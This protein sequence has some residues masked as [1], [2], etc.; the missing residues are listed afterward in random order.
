MISL[1]ESRTASHWR[2]IGSG[3]HHGICLPLFSLR[4]EKSS[5]IGEFN[6]L[7]PLIDWCKSVGF[8]CL[9]LL[10]LNDTGDDP[11]P[12]NALTSCGLDPVYL[13]L[14]D[15]PHAGALPHISPSSVK[16][17]KLE[18]LY[19]YFKRTFIPTPDYQTFCQEAPW[20]EEYAL[21]KACKDTYR[22]ADWRTWPLKQQSL[23]TCQVEDPHHL[24]FYRFLQFL[25]FR[26]LKEVKRYAEKQNVLLKGDIPILISPDSVD[27]WAHRSLFNLQLV[28]GAPPD[29]YSPRGQKWGFPLFQMDEMRRTQFAWWK[30]RLSVAEQF[31][32][33]YRIDHVV[34][35]FRIW[36]IKHDE[37]AIKGQFF[38]PDESLWEP[39]GREMLEILIEASS[40]LPL[41]EDLGTIP[42]IVYSTL[43]E[44]GI[45]GT[46]VM[47][48]QRRWQGDR[49]F[50]PPDEYEPISLTTVSTPDSETLALWWKN[51]PDEAGLFAQSKHWTYAP[52]LTSSQRTEI[53]RDSHHT[54]S[55]FHINLLQEYLAL[56]P[57]L[58]SPRLETERINVPGTSNST[59]WTYRFRPSVEE[60]SQHLPLR[61]AIRKLL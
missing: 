2:R 59:N 44:L 52:L 31:Y 3:P 28:A 60:I 6:D 9:Q 46:K 61:E 12:Y 11:S 43:R 20:L 26:Q 48:W 40:M 15:L 38:P 17:Q 42:P 53:L 37:S 41:A 56:F 50:I 55:L 14:A 35:F 51:S 58:V 36:A 54:A 10:P 34:G 13:S 18:W 23:A 47:R 39:R 21:F 30:Q 22:H 25:S 5:G 32:H 33:L 29:Y 27:V 16:K 57:S 49:S 24:D 19:D 8:N 7:L 4:T 45:C 1:E